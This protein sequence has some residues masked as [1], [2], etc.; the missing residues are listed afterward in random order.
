MN[1]PFVLTFQSGALY[2]SGQSGATAFRENH[3]RVLTPIR[4]AG[5]GALARCRLGCPSESPNRSEASNAPSV[6][7]LQSAQ[8]RTSEFP[9]KLDLSPPSAVGREWSKVTQAVSVRGLTQDRKS[10][11]NRS[12]YSPGARNTVERPPDRHCLGRSTVDRESLFQLDSEG[13]LME[14]QEI[15][16]PRRPNPRRVVPRKTPVRSTNQISLDFKLLHCWS[17]ELLETQTPVGSSRRPLYPTVP[18]LRVSTSACRPELVSDERR[19]SNLEAGT[20]PPLGPATRAADGQRYGEA[21]P[22]VQLR[23]SFSRHGTLPTKLS[24]QS[25]SDDANLLIAGK[26]SSGLCHRTF[27]LGAGMPRSGS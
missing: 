22:R 2:T 10:A 18:E 14:L 1:S 8:C 26:R 9:S 4:S 3:N 5:I 16:W 11:G 21:E 6:H 19:G 20:V 15:P 25:M 13:G 17:T 12:A 7:T 23:G 27:W 24:A